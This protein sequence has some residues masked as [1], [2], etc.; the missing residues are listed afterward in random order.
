MIMHA[1]KQKL[2]P[3]NIHLVTKGSRQAGQESMVSKGILYVKAKSHY[4]VEDFTSD[5]I[6]A[7]AN[8]WCDSNRAHKAYLDRA[9]N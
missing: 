9:S 3:Y 2:T 6:T 8:P 1:S 7:D 5:L 4:F